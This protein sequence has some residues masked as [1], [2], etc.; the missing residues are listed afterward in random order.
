LN[1][2][3][4]I[5]CWPSSCLVLFTASHPPASSFILNVCVPQ[6]SVLLPGFS[7]CHWHPPSHSITLLASMITSL[8]PFPFKQLCSFDYIL[9]CSETAVQLQTP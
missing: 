5:S 8:S 4:F 9:T 6:S 3:S 2:L 7:F 1:S